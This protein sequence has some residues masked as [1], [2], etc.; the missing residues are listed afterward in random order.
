[1]ASV[2]EDGDKTMKDLDF[3]PS[4]TLIVRPKAGSVVTSAFAPTGILASFIAFINFLLDFLKAFVFG[5]AAVPSVPSSKSHETGESSTHKRESSSAT[6]RQ[7]KTGIRT[8]YSNEPDADKKDS[9]D[10]PTY[11]GNSTNQL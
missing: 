3:V 7:R 9:E 1:M 8:L 4:A 11:N 2:I 10:R 6:V 5:T